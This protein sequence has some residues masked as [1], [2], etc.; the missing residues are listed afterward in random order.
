[1]KYAFIAAQKANYPVAMLCGVLQVSRSAFYAGIGLAR[2]T[3]Q[4]E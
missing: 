4:C 2:K 3:H 1:M